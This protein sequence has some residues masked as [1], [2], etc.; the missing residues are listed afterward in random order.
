MQAKIRLSNNGEYHIIIKP[1]I[2]LPWRETVRSHGFLEGMAV[3]RFM[4]TE[5]ALK[6]TMRI[7]NSETLT[8]PV[9]TKPRVKNLRKEKQ[10]ELEPAHH[11]LFYLKMRLDQFTPWKRTKH[12]WPLAVAL[13]LQKEA[14]K[15]PDFVTRI[16]Y[17]PR[18]S[19]LCQ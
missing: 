17:S 4:R 18:Y 3:A 12:L 16:Y 8:R 1:S 11:G 15:K 2:D 6:Q 9:E 13:Q 19:E 7:Y 10:I 14:D 5:N